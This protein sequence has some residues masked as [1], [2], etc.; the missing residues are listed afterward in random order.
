LISL[1]NN[2]QSYT[3][4]SIILEIVYMYRKSCRNS[5]KN[6]YIRE[7]CII[8]IITNCKLMAMIKIIGL[9]YKVWLNKQ[10]KD[11]LY[12]ILQF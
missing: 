1:N 9:L 12:R 2:L 6:W 10:K 8:G 4:I 3:I 7:H 11:K 5:N